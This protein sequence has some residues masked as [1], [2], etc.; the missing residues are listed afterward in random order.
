MRKTFLFAVFAALLACTNETSDGLG[1]VVGTLAQSSY[2]GDSGSDCIELA[3][4]S[5]GCLG[6]H[7]EQA[8]SSRAGDFTRVD[9][10][11][12]FDGAGQ[13]AAVERAPDPNDETPP[14]WYGLNLEDCIPVGEERR[15]L[16]DSLGP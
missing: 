12:Y 7:R 5:R 16:C 14:G 2:C 4:L 6:S 9:D 15:V 1:P 3:E 11:L 8:C 13:L 10:N